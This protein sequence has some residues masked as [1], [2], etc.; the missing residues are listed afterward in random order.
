M[1]ALRRYLLDHPALVWLLGFTLKAEPSSPFGFD[2]AASVP[3]RRQFNRVLRDLSND[4]LQFL[5]DSTVVSIRAAL[6]PEL[7]ATF[8]DV[9]AGDTKAILAWVKENN[10]KQFIKDGRLDKTRQPKGDPDCKLGIKNRRNTSPEDHIDTPP[11]T[12][13][14]EAKPASQLQV[15]VDILWGYASGVAVTKVGDWGEVVLAERTR[16]FNESDISYFTPLLE[17]TERRLGK[18]PKYGAWDTAYDAFYVYEYFHQA[19]DFAAVPLNEGK[20]GAERRFSEDGL[21]LCAAGLAMPLKFAY[22]HR[23]GLVEHQRG[24]HVCPLLYPSAS[25][26]SCPIADAHFAKGGCT[27]TLAMS[28]GA[29]IRHQL[30]RQSEAY[31]LVFNQRTATERINALAKELGIERPKL[32]NQRSITNQN[33]LTYV[34]LNLRCLQRIQARMSSQAAPEE[35]PPT[36]D[37]VLAA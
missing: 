18:R 32:R 7:Q 29:R 17:V 25:G 21:P 14:T 24:K 9:G 1:P 10:P 31:T 27:T 22:Q 37:L 36:C 8:G 11:P 19:G 2:V 35:P 28:V 34:L 33:T 12:P 16:P 26:E 13:T 23:S 4:A 20:R 6:P 30:D 15:G 5:L 3:T